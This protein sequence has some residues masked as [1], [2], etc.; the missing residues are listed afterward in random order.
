M[1]SFVYFILIGALAGWVGGK[2]VKGEGF[3]II[4]NII[5]GIVGAV[6]GGWIFEKLGIAETN[7]LYSIAAAVVGSVVFLL[8]IGLIKRK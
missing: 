6:L 4:G 5:V 7:L 3:G 1:D 2:L 8:I